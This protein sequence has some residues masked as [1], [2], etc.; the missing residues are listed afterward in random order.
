MLGPLNE[1]GLSDRRKLIFIP[2]VGL[3]QVHIII[4]TH[5]LDRS[6][7]D[8]ITIALRSHGRH[9]LF[10]MGWLDILYDEYGFSH[11]TSS[12]SIAPRKQQKKRQRVEF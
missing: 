10:E 5:Y 8:R 1:L 11:I 3:G 2:R 6:G 7:E 9:S 4:A 12:K